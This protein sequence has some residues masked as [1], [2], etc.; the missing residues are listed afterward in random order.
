MSVCTISFSGAGGVAKAAPPT[1]ATDLLLQF[2]RISQSAESAMNLQNPE[3][4]RIL[5]LC[6]ANLLTAFIL[7]I[8]GLILQTSGLILQTSIC[9][10]ARNLQ[11]E[12]DDEPL[13]LFEPLLLYVVLAHMVAYI[14][15][16]LQQHH[17][18]QF[19]Y[20]V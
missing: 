7:Q 13:K 6:A 9:F 8:S 10:Y 14:L 19:Y 11:T 4:C 16:Q 15:F 3:V 12:V 18:E 2:C 1:Q 20:T 5:S 17:V